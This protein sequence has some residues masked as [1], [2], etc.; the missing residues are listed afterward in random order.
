MFAALPTAEGRW[1]FGTLIER[2]G[3]P[4]MNVWGFG[5]DADGELYVM[6]MIGVALTGTSGRVYQIVGAG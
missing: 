6:T 5:Q 2:P 4:A 3:G 1:D